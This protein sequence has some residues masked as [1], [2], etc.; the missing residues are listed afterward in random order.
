MYPPAWQPSWWTGLYQRLPQQ[1]RQQ[2]HLPASH[3]MAQVSRRFSPTDLLSI[4][5]DERIKSQLHGLRRL[6]LQSLRPL[7]L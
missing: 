1:W 6:L 7:R 3:R 5:T 4:V 2:Q